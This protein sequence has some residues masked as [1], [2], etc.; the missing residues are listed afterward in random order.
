VGLAQRAGRKAR[1]KAI[2]AKIANRRKDALYKFSN[3]LVA[4]CGV[5]SDFVSMFCQ[6]PCPTTTSWLMNIV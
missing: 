6:G 1:A 5:I 2:H 3:A 4:R